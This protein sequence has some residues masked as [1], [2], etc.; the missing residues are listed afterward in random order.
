MGESLLM[1]V[2]LVLL[3]EGLMPLVAP[4]QWRATMM[5]VA[6]LRDGQLRFLGMASV[7]VGLLLIS[8]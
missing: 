5:R 6:Q 8:F 4:S 1:A 2:G 3:I 7:L